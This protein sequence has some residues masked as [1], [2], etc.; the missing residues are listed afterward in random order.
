MRPP[1]GTFLRETTSFDVLI[2]KISVGVLA[3]EKREN[4][5]KLTSR[6][7]CTRPTEQESGGGGERKLLIV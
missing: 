5:Q 3:L 2:V 7:T 6:V 4:P 1:K